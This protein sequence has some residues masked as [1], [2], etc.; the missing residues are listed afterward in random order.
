VESEPTD[1]ALSVLEVVARIPPGKVMTYGDVAEYLGSGSARTVGMVMA[2]HGHEVCWH[3]VLRAS[4]EPYDGGL[5][6]LVA[7]GVQVRGD[8]VVL[9]SCRW[10]GTV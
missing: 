6:L 3:R 5:E 10:D 4:G 8:R 2:K 7:E 1:Y 9:A